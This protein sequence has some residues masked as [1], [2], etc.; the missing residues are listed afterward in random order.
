MDWL[1]NF[2]IIMNNDY[3]PLLW[4]VVFVLIS[5]LVISIAERKCGGK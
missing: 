2:L 4:A 1:W 5:I 3:E